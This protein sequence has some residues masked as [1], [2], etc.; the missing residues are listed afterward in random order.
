MVKETGAG[1]SRE[2]AS[3]LVAAGV[4]VIDVSGVGGTSWS[5]VEAYRAEEAEDLQS[6]QMGRL[7]WSWGIPTPASIVECASTGA[8]VIASGGIRSGIDVAKSLALG[9]SLAGTALP[10]L[11][12]ATRET[13][14]VVKSLRGFERALRTSMFLTG[15]RDI[16]KLKSAPIVIRGS[17][18]EWLEE[19]G[20][21]TRK[22]SIYRELAK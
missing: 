19:R 9:A 14:E 5:G 20:Y 10:L 22:F 7:F 8:Q 13:S 6:L 17:T 4:N 12:P 16:S 3:D 1:I 15:S 2:V 11:G 21:D 18:R